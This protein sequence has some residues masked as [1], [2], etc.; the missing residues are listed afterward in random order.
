M[1]ENKTITHDE[2]LEIARRLIAGSF[3][4]DGERLETKD[5]PRF[6]IPCRPDHDDD[7]RM[8][9]YINQQKA[10]HSATREQALSMIRSLKEETDDAA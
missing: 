10:E 3:R 4:R 9:A 7:T 8:L 2:A 5:Q 6:S 1:P